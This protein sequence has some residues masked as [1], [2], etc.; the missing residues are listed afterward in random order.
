MLSRTAEL[1]EVLVVPNAF[2]EQLIIVPSCIGHVLAHRDCRQ[3]ACI[4]YYKLTN[5]KRSKPMLMTFAMFFSQF[6]FRWSVSQNELLDSHQRQGIGRY[7][8]IWAVIIAHYLCYRTWPRSQRQP[9][10]ALAS[11]RF[12]VLMQP[13]KK[14]Q[15]TA[16]AP[17]VEDDL[18]V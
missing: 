2:P 1:S 13:I 9:S 5:A 14:Y 10:T 6:P 7:H 3:I 12:P 4:R 18:S 17:Q 11:S 15:G 16:P 8:L